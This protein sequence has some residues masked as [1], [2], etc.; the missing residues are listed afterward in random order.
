METFP[1]HHAGKIVVGFKSGVNEE[2]ATNLVNSLSLKVSSSVSRILPPSETLF[3]VLVPEGEED[4]WISEFK[5][6]DL[7]AYAQR[8][9]VRRLY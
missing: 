7:V 2:S 1:S 4:K 8:L 3:F 9:P 5:K 6:N